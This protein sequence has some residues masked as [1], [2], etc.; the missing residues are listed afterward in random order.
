MNRGNI[1]LSFSQRQLLLNLNNLPENLKN[2][3]TETSTNQQDEDIFVSAEELEKILDLLPP[4][5]LSSPNQI[6][7]REILTNYLRNL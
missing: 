4:P 3:L 5:H 2:K 7:L 6:E 1:Q